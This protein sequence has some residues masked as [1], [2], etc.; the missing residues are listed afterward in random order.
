MARLDG[1][2]VTTWRLPRGLNGYNAGWSADGTKVV[3]QLRSSPSANLGALYVRDLTTDT[4]T[5]V[6]DLPSGPLES[7]NFWDWAVRPSL[8]PDGQ[9]VLYAL[10]RTEVPFNRFNV[11]SVPITGGEL[12]LELRRASDSLVEYLPDGRIAYYSGSTGVGQ[13]IMAIDEG[14]GRRTLATAPTIGTEFIEVSADGSKIAFEAADSPLDTGTI[15]VRDLATGE[16][17]QVVFGEDAQWVDD[18]TLLVIPGQ[19]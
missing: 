15:T 3:Y 4:D 19:N 5:R 11:W 12:E 1:S 8:S 13:R 9:R 17:A 2:T 10:P 18:D 14:G 16:A 6:A 7:A